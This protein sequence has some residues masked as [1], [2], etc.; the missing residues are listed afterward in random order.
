[1][2][3]GEVDGC[4]LPLN[5]RLVGFEGREVGVLMKGEGEGSSIGIS[6]RQAS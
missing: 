5:D 1:M 4:W 6:N 3:L 2:L